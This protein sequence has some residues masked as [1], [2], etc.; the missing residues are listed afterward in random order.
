MHPNLFLEKELGGGQLKR[1]VTRHGCNWQRARS[2][3]LC[4]RYT[5]KFFRIIYWVMDG[6]QIGLYF[7]PAPILIL[8]VAKVPGQGAKQTENTY[9]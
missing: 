3:H 9:V 4:R 5:Q 2:D 6:T 7:L 8:G 1:T